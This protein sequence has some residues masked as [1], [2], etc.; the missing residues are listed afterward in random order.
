MVNYANGYFFVV[1]LCLSGI[2]VIIMI[3]R[4]LSSIFCFLFLSMPMIVMAIPASTEL[5]L[6]ESERKWLE[7]HPTVKFTGDPNW[8]PYEAFDSQD[9]Y[10]GIVAEHLHLIEKISG[11]KFK[12]SPSKTWTESTLKAKQGLVD[13]LSETDDSDLKSHLNFTVPY[14]SNPIVIAMHIRE[15]YVESISNIKH[16]KIAL[17]KDYGYVSKIRRNYSDINFVTADDIHDGLISVSTGKVDA[18]LCTLALCSYTI[19]KLGLNNVKITGKT[20]FDTKLAFGVQKNLPELLSILNMAINKISHEQ[21][22]LILDNWIHDKF[23]EKTDYTLVFQVLAAAIVLLSI[24]AVWIRRLSREI[25]LRIATEEELKSAEEVLR[26]SHQRLL[27]HR[28]YTPLGI[29]EWNTSFEFIDWNPAAQHIF[30]Y[31]KE[32]VLDTILQKEYYLKARYK[33]LIRYGATC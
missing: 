7:L 1:V 20:E 8:L 16:R 22:Q 17:I 9:N 15:N 3:H 27:L 6:N 26:F 12:M 19:S 23:L 31:T 5:T 4:K 29:I 2:D 14:I 13:V 32:E 24:F 30:G 18:L 21:Q 28:E 33:E 10:I 25:N 11:L